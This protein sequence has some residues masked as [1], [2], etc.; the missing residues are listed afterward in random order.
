MLTQC[1]ECRTVFRATLAQLEAAAGRVRCGHCRTVFDALEAAEPPEPPPA[2]APAPAIAGVDEE[3]SDPLADTAEHEILDIEI[4]STPAIEI[5]ME[6]ERIDIDGVQFAAEAEEFAEQAREELAELHHEFQRLTYEEA[7]GHIHEQTGKF[8]LGTLPPL[9][10]AREPS[11]EPASIEAPAEL[12]EIVPSALIRPTQPRRA[13]LWAI[14]SALVTLVLIA[15]LVHFNRDT[16]ARNAL[17]GGPLVRTYESLGLDISPT[18]NLKAYELRQWGATADPQPG[19]ALRVRASLFNNA[20][21]AQPYPLLRLTLQ[22]RFGGQV[23]ARDL[24]P[25][26]Y[27]PGARTGQLLAAGQRIDA[28]IAL[29]DPGKEA[30]GFEIDVCLRETQ[31]EQRKTV[32]ANEPH[33]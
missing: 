13:W 25:E 7:A 27:L 6:G 31:G 4:E 28:E 11:S 8:Q 10:G 17:I 21:F 32:C 14:G 12:E 30:V 24:T 20:E 26:E 29:V 1:P 16:L 18:W 15:Q 22:D 5:T 2:P 23:G 33:T 19:G 9:S 3:N